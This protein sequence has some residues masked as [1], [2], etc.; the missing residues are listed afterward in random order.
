MAGAALTFRYRILF[1]IE[2]STAL[3]SS[4]KNKYIIASFREACRNPR[5]FHRWMT[6][7]TWANLITKFYKPS[8]ELQYT[9]KELTRV[10]SL[11]SSRWLTALLD[12]D[13]N[14]VPRN[15]F[16]V[17]RKS[18]KP[19]SSTS[20]IH[21]F[22]A[23]EEGKAPT[24]KT[25]DKWFLEIDDGNDLLNHVTTRSSL[26]HFSDETNDIAQSFST[27]PPTKKH[28]CN[29]PAPG[30]LSCGQDSAV[31]S[32][33]SEEHRAEPVSSSPVASSPPALPCYW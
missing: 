14:N 23:T 4:E 26:L 28:K 33:A 22:Y 16:G 7:D 13:T 25:A 29:S 10:L 15:H 20:T 32:T 5:F 27:E 24:R 3:Q 8:L 2:M 9:G 11:K 12:V 21:C 18:Y 6:A 19:K 31:G 30:K 1:S 17:F